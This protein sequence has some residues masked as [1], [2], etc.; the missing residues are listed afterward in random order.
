MTI[1]NFP[2]GHTLRSGVYLQTGA[3]AAIAV[4]TIIEIARELA[5]QRQAE[6]MP[7]LAVSSGD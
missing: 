6:I 7:E 3:A 5:A 2:A 1:S 4:V